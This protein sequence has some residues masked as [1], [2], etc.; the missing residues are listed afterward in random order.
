M[1]KQIV[2]PLVLGGWLGL[3]GC[4]GSAKAPPPAPTAA[5]AG[6]V[7]PP[8]TPAP[9][10]P[11]PPEAVPFSP[12]IQNPAGAVTLRRA[13]EL[14]LGQHPLLAS[15][16]WGHR[17]ARAAMEQARLFPNPEFVAE[18]ENFGGS[19]DLSGFDGAEMTFWLGQPLL[20]GGK[21]GRAVEVARAGAELA[22]WD[23]EAARLAVLTATTA[24][25]AEVLAAQ[26]NL[27]LARQ[28][29][30]VAQRVHD[31]V[32]A[33]VEA[34]SVSPIEQTRTRVVLARARLELTQSRRRLE[35]ARSQL[36]ASWGAEQPEFESATGDLAQ[37]RPLP[38]LATVS[39]WLERN[40]DVARWSAEI[41]QRQARL[42]LEKARVWPDVTISGGV[43][44][45]EESDD[46]A[47]VA[48]LSFPL[49][50][51]NRNQGNIRAARAALEQAR[52][53][54]RVARLRAR[55]TLVTA[56]NALRAAHA[57]ATALQNEVVPNARRA[58]T[59][60]EEA[61]R[62]GKF[63]LMDVLDTQRTLFAT[64]I[65]LNDALAEY[66][67]RRAEVEGL[68]GRPLP[69]P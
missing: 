11:R 68:L 52:A 60:T 33:Q 40:P 59:A 6:S 42:K 35:T 22:G 69:T 39:A 21:R 65:Q 3:A 32:T 1:K 8:N 44:R 34:G 66:H 16:A 15:T 29:F 67:R 47:F 30:A 9:P 2:Y 23:Y 49:P 38:A 20:L 56:F 48:S 45:F 31:S 50:F 54:A 10:R 43:R 14:A 12:E 7:S 19:G 51:W 18:F 41:A 26:K 28:T 25:F 63:R 62:E 36:A 5:S 17:A 13:L 58:F 64:Q 27:E 55:Q 37:I 24:A 46:H 4:A 61:Y 57:T 53:D